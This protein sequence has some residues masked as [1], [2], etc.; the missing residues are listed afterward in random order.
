MKKNQ[1]YK[2]SA[3]ETLDGKWAHAVLATVVMTAISG[4][5]TL[6][7]SSAEDTSSVL[8]TL[9][10]L[11][12][13]VCLSLLVAG[14]LYMGYYNALKMLKNDGDEKVL[15]NMFRIAFSNVVR[16]GWGMMLIQIFT[17][18]W[19]LLLIVP[20]VI[21]AMSYAMTPFILNDNPELSAN[22]AIN[23]SMAMMQGHK[24]KF[25]LLCLSFIGWGILAV[26]T[27]GI[28]LFWL[29]PYV[30]S[31]YVAFYEDVKAEYDSK[32]INQ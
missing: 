20:G 15:K 1:E 2:N 5:V 22:Q 16:N 30:H 6:F 8:I 31:T 11:C 3:L 13:Y 27:L 18:L 14:P 9:L 29:F 17:F 32:L 12:V 19:M 26:L 7:S 21:K 10:L 28:G 23:R 24:M 25:F 4:V